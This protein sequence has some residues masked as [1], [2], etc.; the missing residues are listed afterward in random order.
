MRTYREL[1]AI[2][3]A[4]RLLV[5]ATFPRLS[6]S[7]V[8]LSIFFHVQAETGSVATAGLA[9]GAS[10]LTGALTAG[11]RGKIV[12]RYGQT[13]PL[14]VLVPLYTTS[15]VLL[16]LFA[17]SPT[18]AVALSLLNG[19]CAPPINISIRPLW[20]DIVGEDRVR[21][22]YGLD[23]AHMNLV[24]LLGPVIATLLAVNVDTSV[25]LYAVAGAMAIGGTLLALLPTSRNWVPEPKPE[26]EISLWR[27]P[28]MRLLALEGIAMGVASGFIYI[29]I[30]ALATLS[31]DRGAAGPMVA[32]MGVGSILGTVWAGAKAKDIPPLTGLRLSVLLYAIALI[33]LPWVPIGPWMALVL[34]IASA[35]VGPAHV[36]YLETVDLVR[37]RGTAVAALASLW[38]IEGTAAA[39]AQ[40]IAGNLAEAVS[41]QFTMLLGSIVVFASPLIFSIGMRTVLRSAAA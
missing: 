10:S 8:G 37:P 4:L 36:F 40:A 28:A 35:V 23:S 25:A 3:G 13:L 7:M 1:L 15:N 39:F 14:Y 20:K 34:F 17:H 41:P 18:T 38:M 5:V 31:G 22:A 26:G 33:P 19:A 30:P 12:D 11:P 27:S 24:Q 6:Y 21:T 9:V 16:G 29:S 32:T 2:P